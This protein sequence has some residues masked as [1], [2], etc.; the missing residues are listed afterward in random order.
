MERAFCSLRQPASK[1]LAGHQEGCDHSIA[2]RISSES[3]VYSTIPTSGV[4]VDDVH[5]ILY[6]AN[7]AIS[8]LQACVEKR[9]F[10]PG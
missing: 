7:R 2:A 8:V 3:D 1:M 6:V 4:M 5:D 10:L 9:R